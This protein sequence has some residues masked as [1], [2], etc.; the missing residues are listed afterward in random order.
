MIFS[1]GQI[2]HFINIIDSP[3]KYEVRNWRNQEYVRANMIDS[4]VISEEQHEKYLEHLQ[5]S[6]DQKVFIAMLA[7]EP[8]AVM[9]YRINRE[10]G[11]VVSGSYLI[12]EEYMGKGLGVILGYVRMEYIFSIMPDGLMRTVVMETNQKNLALQ[13]DFG[14]RETGK[15]EVV[16]SNGNREIMVT[17]EMTHLEWEKKRPRIERLM[18]RLMP[19]ESIHLIKE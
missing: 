12:R 14:C 4:N 5:A 8:I 18:S 11:Y 16:R 17:L 6:D 7:D 19:L 15:E 10:E 3:Y 13:K 2:L 1:K 9:T